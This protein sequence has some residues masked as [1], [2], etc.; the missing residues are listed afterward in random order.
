MEVLRGDGKLLKNIELDPP[1]RHQEVLQNIAIILDTVAG[2]APMVRGL[3]AGGPFYG[4]PLNVSENEIVAHVY[5]QI[6]RYEPRA[7]IAH[8]T[9]ETDHTTGLLIPTIEIEGVREDEY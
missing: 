2:S 5:D 8:V 6:E 3:G 1:N 7:I 4:R 9:V